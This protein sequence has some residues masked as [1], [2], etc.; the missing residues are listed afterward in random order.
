[1]AGETN[2]AD[3]PNGWHRFLLPNSFRKLLRTPRVGP[4]QTGR[5]RELLNLYGDQ[6]I[7]DRMTDVTQLVGV[8]L[9]AV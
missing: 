3:S 1:M 2:V 9:A 6:E 7:P 5:L 8:E 4:D